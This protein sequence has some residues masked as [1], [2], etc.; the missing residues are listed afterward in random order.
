MM[1]KDKIFWT[2]AALFMLSIVLFAISGQ[3]EWLFLLIGSYLLRPT[4]ASL[5]LAGHGIDERQMTIQHRS[6]NIAFAV[7]II[8]SIV[9]SVI[10][11]KKDDHSWELFNIVIALGVAS[12]ALFNVLLQKN[13]REAGARIIMTAGMMMVLFACLEGFSIGTLFESIPGL[14]VTGIG[15]TARKYPKPVSVLVFIAAIGLLVVILGKGF[16]I[17]QI[18]SALIVCV[19]LMLAGVSL[20]L[21]FREQDDAV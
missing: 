3:Q 17:G 6:G 11:A 8:A 15:W 12:K 18:A 16:T 2:A 9:M 5:G 1:A 14:V 19:P 7:M 13:Y 20:L 4:M 21:P 10:Q